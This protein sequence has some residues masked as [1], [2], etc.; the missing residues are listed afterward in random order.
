MKTLYKANSLFSDHPAA[1]FYAARAYDV[2]GNLGMAANFYR[3][4]LSLTINP[5][6]VNYS[7]MRLQFLDSGLNIK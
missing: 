7:H 4:V 3:K 6:Y 5:K 2:L 1:I